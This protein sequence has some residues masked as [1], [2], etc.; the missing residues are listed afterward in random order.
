MSTTRIYIVEDDALIAMELIDRLTRLGYEVCGKAARGEQALEEILRISPDL[1]LMDIRLAGELTGIDTAARLR[2]LLNVPIVFLSAFSDSQLL[3]EALG[4]EPFGYLIKPFE[5]R[6]LQTT[7]QAAACQYR[8]QCSLQEAN[9]RLDET[10]RQ[11][12]TQLHTLNENLERLI[13][14]RTDEL[15]ESEE[16]LRTLFEQAAVGVAEIDTPTGRF[17]RINRKYGEIVDYSM[18]EMLARDFMTI[19]HPEDLASDLAQ[20][21]R[22]RRGELR[23]FTL[24]KRYIR[25]DGS[26]VWVE[27]TCSPLWARG[28]APTRHMA[29]IKDISER[30]QV[31]SQLRLTQFAVEQAA[32][33]VLWADDTKRFVYVNAAACRSLGYTREELL[34]LRIPD[35]A[36]RHDPERFQQRLTAI[37]QGRS[38]TYESLHRR[39]D[40]TEFPVEASIAYLEHEGTGYTCGI[41]RDITERKQA[42]LALR[43]SEERFRILFEQAAVG[44]AQVEATTGRF[45]RVNQKYCDITGYSQAEALELNVRQLTYPD[46]REAS[47]DSMARLTAGEISEFKMEKRYLRKDGSVVWVKLVVSPMSMPGA[48]SHFNIA[49]VQDITERKEAEAALDLLQDQVR[50]MQK[51]EAIGQLAGGVAHDF[52]NILTAIL[53]N[54]EMACAKIAA[55]HPAQTNLSRILEAG[56]RASRLV[57]QILT[58]THQQEPTRTVL[59][60]SP[61]VQ[62]VLAMLRATLP[63]GIELTATEDAATPPILADATQIHQV[64]MNLC[65]NAWHA[66]HDQPGRIAVDLAPMTLTQPLQTLHATLPPGGYARLSVRDSGCGMAPDTVGRIF[67]PFFTTKPTGEGTGLGLSV[68]HGIVRGHEAAIV[69]ESEP[70]QGTT[71]HLYFPATEALAQTNEPPQTVPLLQQGR[72]CRLLYLDDEAMLVELIRAQFEPLGYRITGC[73]RPAEALA[74]VRAD[75][76][77]F[78]VVVTDYNMPEMSGL[79]VARAFSLLRADL[80]VVL[81][82]GYLSP[83]AQ[84]AI[85]A[86]GITE[87]VY[88]PTLLQQLGAVIARLRTKPIP[89]NAEP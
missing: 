38:A 62:E 31:E 84:A 52:N 83:A 56:D 28:V 64:L 49:V 63:A 2:R 73:T 24:E 66:L 61:V 3:K 44:V 79:E 71:F 43:E 6:E 15:R 69:V 13:A 10:V 48:E 18:E 55:N 87:I 67:D 41:V 11:R 78:D 86:E 23:E 37:Q 12:D 85:R 39:K 22:L 26:T 7:I 29:V 47:R 16:R 76:G 30:K 65:T 45:V 77:G 57:Q 50:Q 58:F 70:G 33:A 54:A 81:V 42:E 88:K 1:V 20:M 8:R 19:T 60:L 51:M 72:G 68:V 4:T 53:G 89:G 82:S 75:P 46:D 32:D 34:T 40:G 80:P 14:E 25:K 27:L 35:I 21:E 17:I 5:E 36:P 74:A 59:N 9:Q